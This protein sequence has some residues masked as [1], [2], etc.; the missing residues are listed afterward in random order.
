VDGGAGQLSMTRSIIKISRHETN[1]AQRN[2][3][4]DLRLLASRRTATLDLLRHLHSLQWHEHR[5]R[6]AGHP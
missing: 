1:R 5:L 6:I 3:L 2:G 4:E